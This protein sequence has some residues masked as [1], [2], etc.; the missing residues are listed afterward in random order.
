M[1][2]LLPL[3]LR[4]GASGSETFRLDQVALIT[5]LEQR[6]GSRFDEHGRTAN[7]NFRPRRHRWTDAPKH[8][9]VY[10]TR[11]PG[12]SRRLPTR[13]RVYDCKPVI[14]R[15]HLIQLLAIDDVLEC[16]R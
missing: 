16:P 4:S 15:G 8:A 12:P 1:V 7:E 5:E 13:Q 3:K 11:A 2:V 9:P 14:A 6:L 10:P